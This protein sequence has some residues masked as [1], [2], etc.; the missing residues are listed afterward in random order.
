MFYEAMLLFL[1]IYGEKKIF[2]FEFSHK[3][4]EK[5]T[6]CPKIYIQNLGREHSD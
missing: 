2:E 5:F 1:F 4:A 6:P 3:R